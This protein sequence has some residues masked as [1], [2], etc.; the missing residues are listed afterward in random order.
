LSSGAS[1]EQRTGQKKGD[2]ELNLVPVVNCF[3]VL[4]AYVLV[5]MSFISLSMFETGV[6]ATAPDSP[7]ASTN[8][9]LTGPPLNLFVELATSDR[10]QLRLSGGAQHQNQELMVE[11]KPGG[12]DLDALKARLGEIK[13]AN[14]DLNEANVSAE[15]TIRYKAIIQVIEAVKTQL[16]KVFLASG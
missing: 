9:P 16:P 5:S 1:A 13:A 8:L 10:I 4:I 15:N 2:V 7:L 14:P 6:A 3:T 11:A 12:M